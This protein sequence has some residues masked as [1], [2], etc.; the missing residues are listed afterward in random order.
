MARAVHMCNEQ[1][2]TLAPCSECDE[3]EAKVDKLREDFDECCEEVKSSYVER[4]VF[5]TN[6]QA[7]ADVGNDQCERVAEL[8]DCCANSQP[9][10]T[11]GEGIHIN[12]DNVISATGSATP[13]MPVG[14]VVITNTNVAPQYAGNWR[15]IDKEFAPRT[16]VLTE[17]NELYWDLDM[18]GGG[19]ATNSV[20]MFHSGHSIHVRAWW[21]SARKLDDSSYYLLGIYKKT[22]FDT[23][24]REILG[25]TGLP[26]N[27]YS[28]GASDGDNLIADLTWS[29]DNN[30]IKM[31]SSDVAKM[32]ST[33]QA[34]NVWWA[35]YTFYIPAE[36]MEDSFCNK[37]YWERI[38]DAPSSDIADLPYVSGTTY[39]TK[40]Y[41][42]GV[43]DG[44]YYYADRRYT[45]YTGSLD[46]DDYY[47]YK[48]YEWD[49][50]NQSWTE[51][52]TSGTVSSTASEPSSSNQYYAAWQTAWGNKDL[53]DHGASTWG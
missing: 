39:G 16:Q 9:R 48:L 43:T 37:F 34:G 11:A 41:G 28:L 53:A 44:K 31:T 30:K 40:A 19:T 47:Q 23:P 6:M 8:E 26:I 1:D 51:V 3:L 35:D 33:V 2:L 15:L 25:I 21:N 38:P 20:Y 18:V 46:R 14:S 36:Y 7:I 49:V 42:L 17:G 5:D 29:W 12:Q 50:A 13:E 22:Q 24:P 4:S 27:G 45:E 52:Y 10:L 32:V